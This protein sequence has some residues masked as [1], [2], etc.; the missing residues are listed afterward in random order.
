ME[1]SQAATDGDR[2]CPGT[3]AQP[4]DGTVMASIFEHCHPVKDGGR[5]AHPSPGWSFWMDTVEAG[6]RAL[7]FSSGQES[8]WLSMGGGT[9]IRRNEHQMPT[10][11]LVHR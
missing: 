10:A 6:R 11:F 3:V 9:V 1:R 4:S 5:S 7:A 2:C 8:L